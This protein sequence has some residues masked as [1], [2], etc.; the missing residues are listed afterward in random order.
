M[1]TVFLVSRSPPLAPFELV[2]RHAKAVD[3]HRERAVGREYPVQ[4]LQRI[5]IKDRGAAIPHD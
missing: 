5:P 4:I 3:G 2:H 1:S